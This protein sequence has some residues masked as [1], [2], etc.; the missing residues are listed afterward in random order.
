[1]K[2]RAPLKSQEEI[3]TRILDIF[4]EDKDEAEQAFSFMIEEGIVM[5]F[6][7]LLGKVQANIISPFLKSIL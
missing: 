4:P 5:N 3:L 2:F 7:M 6:S 1:M